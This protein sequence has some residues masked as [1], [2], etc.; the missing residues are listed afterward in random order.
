MTEDEAKT[1]WCHAFTASHTDPRAREYA[2]GPEAGPFIHA[3]IG[4]SCM[5]WRWTEAKRAQAFDEAVRAFMRTQ[6]KPNAATAIQKLY[7]ERGH[8][9]ER[10]EGGCG[11]AGTPQ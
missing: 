5:A 7:A 11:L 8:E 10:T 4:S 6:D 3:C 2:N 9:F 1:K